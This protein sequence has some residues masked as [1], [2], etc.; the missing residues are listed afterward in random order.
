ME[1][2][3]FLLILYLMLFD[4]NSFCRNQID[5]F[6]YKEKKHVVALL[7]NPSDENLGSLQHKIHMNGIVSK[8]DLACFSFI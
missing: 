1:S 2:K 6:S 5:S 3:E 4:V 8:D 7:H